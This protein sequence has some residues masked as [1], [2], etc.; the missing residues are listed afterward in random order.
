MKKHNVKTTT[1][2]GLDSKKAGIDIGAYSVFVCVSDTQGYQEVREY[3]TFTRDLRN[4]ANWLK[5]RGIKSVA[6]ESTGVYWIPV[7]E[8]L[9]Q[10]CE[11]LLVNAH[12]MKNVPGRKTDIK[13]AQW[14]QQLHSHGLLSGSFRPSDDCVCLRAYV[15]TCLKSRHM[16]FYVLFLSVWLPFLGLVD[17]LCPAKGQPN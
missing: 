10:S 1:L 14:I 12:H 6:M 9:D 2:P 11:V 7:F 15:R 4:M 5:E 13:D 3:P 8:I 16:C 17:Q